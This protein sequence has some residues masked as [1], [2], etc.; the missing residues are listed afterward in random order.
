VGPYTARCSVGT[1]VWKTVGGRKGIE[2]RGGDGRDSEWRGCQVVR[3]C[4]AKL[5]RPV[6]A[7]LCCSSY[8]GH[9]VDNFPSTILSTS[10]IPPQCH[11][12]VGRESW[13]ALACCYRLL[14]CCSLLPF[15]L[16]T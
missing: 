5:S 6:F 3:R 9:T 13:A 2:R 12:I 4:R 15:S 10:S 7:N 1:P 8:D 11:F 16:L 14:D